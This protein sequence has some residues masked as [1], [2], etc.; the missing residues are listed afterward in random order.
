[1]K[2][3]HSWWGERTNC[4]VLGSLATNQYSKG[5]GE[6]LRFATC[7][8]LRTETGKREGKGGLFPEGLTRRGLNIFQSSSTRDLQ[9]KIWGEEVIDFYKTRNSERDRKGLGNIKGSEGGT[10]VNAS[11]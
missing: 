3:G 2:V 8:K 1:M 10:Q 11:A 5:M 6:D 4:S 9:R 7:R